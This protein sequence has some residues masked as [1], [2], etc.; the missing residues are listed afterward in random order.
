MSDP[1]I[2][3]C[4][5]TTPDALSAAAEA[6]A[7]HVGFVWFAKS[8]RHLPAERAKMLAAKTP[9]GL[10]RVLMTVDI[11][12]GDLAAMIEAVEPNVLQL[13]GSESPARVA[14]LRERFG[15]QIIK[16]IA[17]QSAEDLPKAREF[18]GP[19]DL[20]LFD[21]R[22]PEGA[23]R[24]GGHGTP[25]EWTLL[26]GQAFAKPVILSGGLTPENV[27]E[28]I[29]LTGVRGVDVSSGVESQLGVKSPAKVRA[30]VAAAKAAME[31]LP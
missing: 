14:E 25:F 23:S 21:A 13:H 7:T 18:E 10:S 29:A 12:D 5:V 2:K 6:G 28:A 11:A 4:G 26:R 20:I 30:F 3:I 22:P 9:A 17:V 27:A 8:P 16:V 19:A 31:A 1:I 24:P 15:R